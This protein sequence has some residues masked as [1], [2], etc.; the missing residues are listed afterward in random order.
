MHAELRASDEIIT[1][2]EVEDELRQAGAEGD[3]THG[4]NLRECGL[5]I[6]D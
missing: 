2:T 6:A 1:A 5:R 4:R 3:E